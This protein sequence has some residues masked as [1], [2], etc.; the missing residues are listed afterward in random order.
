MS[1]LTL[2]ISQKQRHGPMIDPVRMSKV[3]D[4]NNLKDEIIKDLTGGQKSRKD[5]S[6]LRKHKTSESS[7]KLINEPGNSLL[8]SKKRM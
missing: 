7:S 6:A 5:T 1:D 3:T 4:A 2:K 8:L